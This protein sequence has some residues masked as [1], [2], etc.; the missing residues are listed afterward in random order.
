M[1]SL[2]FN[3][4]ICWYARNI[5]FYPNGRGTGLGSYISLYLDL[6]EAGSLPSGKKIFAE[7]TL[8]ILDQRYGRHLSGK[9]NTTLLDLLV[10]TLKVKF[11]L[12]LHGV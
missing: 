12:N 6:A 7:F 2:N 9:G 10:I 8:R 11:Q 5:R 4:L 3:I 1:D